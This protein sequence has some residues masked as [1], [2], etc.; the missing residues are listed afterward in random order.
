[1]AFVAKELARGR[2]ALD[3]IV[4]GRQRRSNGLADEGLQ[5]PKRRSRLLIQ[6]DKVETLDD[7]V[8]AA[9]LVCHLTLISLRISKGSHLP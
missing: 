4:E 5:V 7:T 8:L 2:R 1:M 3:L 9:I 6:S